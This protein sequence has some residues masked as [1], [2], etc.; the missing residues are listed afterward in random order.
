MLI[1]TVGFFLS[2]VDIKLILHRCGFVGF[3]DC[4]N[5]VKAFCQIL[6]IYGDIFNLKL[7]QD[8]NWFIR[9]P[10][11]LLSLFSFNVVMMLLN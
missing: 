1:L 3:A 9:Q 4:L 8:W 6:L 10:D 2:D 11:Y 7:M 5:I